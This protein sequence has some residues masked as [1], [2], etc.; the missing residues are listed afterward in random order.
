MKRHPHKGGLRVT[1]VCSNPSCNHTHV[2]TAASGAEFEK[3]TAKIP[4]SKHGDLLY[5]CP[6]HRKTYGNRRRRKTK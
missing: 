3:I 4:R 2:V 5:K 6:K 1:L